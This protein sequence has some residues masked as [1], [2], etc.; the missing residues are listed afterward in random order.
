M[1]KGKNI[2]KFT[3]IVNRLTKGGLMNFNNKK[4]VLGLMLGLFALQPAYAAGLLK[5]RQSSYHDL[6]IND[7]KVNV[8]LEDGYAIT[9]VEQVFYNPNVEDLEAIYSFPLPE[10]ASVSEFTMWI[11]GKPISGEVLEKKRAKKVY[12]DQKAKGN[13][14]G[15]TEKNEYKTFEISVYPVR[16][17]DSTK[18]RLCYIQ[19]AKVDSGIGAYV[20]PLKDGEVDDYALSFW[21]TNDKVENNFSFDL[22]L[23]SAYP[24]ENLRLP[25]HPNATIANNDQVWTVH[26]DN[27]AAPEEESSVNSTNNEFHLNED[28]VVYYRH[29]ENLPGSVDLVTYK[30]EGADEGTFMM[31]LSPGMDLKPIVKGRDWV[32]VLDISG[33][34]DNKYAILAEGVAKALKQLND[35][36]RFRIIVFNSHA[37][38]ISNGFVTATAENV[39]NYIKK[40]NNV[41]PGN[42]TN[43]FDAVKMG[44]KGIDADRT[45]SIILVT[46]GVAN[47]G[48][49]K[50][51][52]YIELARKHDIRVFTFI[53]GNSANRPLLEALTRESNGFALT[54]SNSDDI[55][56]KIL[57]AK[58]KVN[59]ESFNNVELKISGLKTYDVY[60]KRVG[61]LY[62]GQQLIVFGHY[63]GSGEVSVELSGRVS[64]KERIYNTKFDLDAYAD[65]NPEIE[66]LWAYSKIEDYMQQ[67]DDFGDDDGL[68]NEI[69]KL[70]VNYG[71]VTDYTSM[72]VLEEEVYK[73]LGIDRNNQKRL[74]KENDARK[75]RT[76]RGVKSNRVDNSSPMFSGNRPSMNI[77]VGAI[78]PISL[79]LFLPLLFGLKR[80]ED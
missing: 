44:F 32:F 14:T 70:G 28:I 66:R 69:I 56:G 22:E 59:F 38:E 30:E 46:D 35:K 63:K 10:N 65:S 73:E 68:K 23:R 20:Y 8:V 11:D 48:E 80:K 61:N 78:D 4:I 52:S 43:L 50:H 1:A 64:G 19:T 72:V 15:I 9:T 2:K 36:D 13:N 6:K 5:A 74:H 57:Q 60:P 49:T 12:E 27:Y 77:G 62:R 7:H 45:T 26:I 58:S 18:I 25:K 55:I 76:Q 3:Q 67:I 24:V 54:V 42:S 71:L 41:S 53:M 29:K 37:K 75:N 51:K 16:A 47:V 34:M 79:L 17:N 21:S 33:S 40:V 31:T 39:N